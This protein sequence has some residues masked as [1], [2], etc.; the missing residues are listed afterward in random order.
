M[1]WKGLDVERQSFK[2][3]Q[4]LIDEIGPNLRIV[5]DGF[6]NEFLQE[7]GAD[8]VVRHNT[9]KTLYLEVKGARK[10][11]PSIF[12][13][14]VQHRETGNDG[15]IHSLRSDLLL[16]VYCDTG[17]GYLMK[18]DS[19]LRYYKSHQQNLHYI[20]P[21]GLMTG[22]YLVGWDI[23]MSECGS[24]NIQRV[25]LNET[26]HYHQLLMLGL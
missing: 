8:S 9:G 16:W 25:N 20:E 5:G 11:Y 26:D 23:L 6:I 12:I 17:T 7:R 22:G 15:W 1:G 21:E 18:V 19:L 14:A 10:T 24:R 13:E 2:M 3:A 4:P